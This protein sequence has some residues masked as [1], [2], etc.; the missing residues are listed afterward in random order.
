M[1]NPCDVTAK[2]RL[3]LLL[4]V[5]RAAC[6]QRT[7]TA[8][9]DKR[10]TEKMPSIL[11]GHRYLPAAVWGDHNQDRDPAVPTMACM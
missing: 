9:R 4:S 5:M 8:V 10:A 2:L 7:S 3:Q 6:G 11:Q 1:E